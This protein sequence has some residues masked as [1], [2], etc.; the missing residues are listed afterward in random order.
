MNILFITLCNFSS[1]YERNIYTD[2]LRKFME[3]GHQVF[4]MSPNEGESRK[5]TIKIVEGNCTIFRVKVG[6]IQKTNAVRKGINMLRLEWI[7][8]RQYRKNLKDE[9]IDLVL[10]STPPITIYN[11]IAYVKKKKNAFTYLLLKDIFPQNAADLQLMSA[12]GILY[13]YFRRVEKQIYRISDYIGCMSEENVRYILRN[14]PYLQAKKVG[15]SPNCVAVEE[16]IFTRSISREERQEVLAGHGIPADKRIFL[17]GGNLGKPQDIPFVIECLKETGKDS[18]NYYVVCGSGTEY[19]KLQKFVETEKPQNIKLI[20]GLPHQE[21]DRLV[22]ACDVG[23]LFLDYR[24]T[25]PNFPSR[26]LSYMEYGLPVLACTDRNTDIGK[27]IEEGGFGWWCPSNSAEG[28]REKALRIRELSDEELK[29][30]GEMGRRY[31]KEFYNV[32]CQYRDIMEVV[33]GKT[34]I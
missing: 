10:Y 16:D 34:G 4:V 2:L 6:T 1:V 28:F 21:Y 29:E 14:N 32:D 15:Q 30:K 18:G 23:L 33:N 19:G 24:F 25:I 9:H 12:R 26:V 13:R 11:T 17:Y 5:Q 20:S 22:R 8:K 3:D 31:L 7:M 27:V